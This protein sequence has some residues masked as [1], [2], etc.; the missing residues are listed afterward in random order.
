MF[1]GGISDVILNI[2]SI[3]LSGFVL[4][5][6]G[7]FGEYIGRIYE[8]CKT[9]IGAAFGNGDAPFFCRMRWR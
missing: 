4:I 1:S 3:M 5:F 2:L 9:V 7:I 8:E 6:M